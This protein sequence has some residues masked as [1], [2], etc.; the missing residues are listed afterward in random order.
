MIPLE[1]FEFDNKF[2]GSEQAKECGFCATLEGADPEGT[3][4][5]IWGSTAFIMSNN[6]GHPLFMPLEHRV[7]DETDSYSRALLKSTW[8]MFWEQK[9]VVEDIY[10][11]E[12]GATGFSTKVNEG[13]QQNIKHYHIHLEAWRGAKDEE[14]ITLDK[15]E[16]EEFRNAY[17]MK[18]WPKALIIDVAAIRR[19]Q[20]AEFDLG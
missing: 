11:K 14:Q 16:R 18:T 6:D 15:T 20:E 8:D 5:D 13:T 3:I 1:Q 10:R 2:E 12:Y 19:A 4:V 17:I 9:P 7:G